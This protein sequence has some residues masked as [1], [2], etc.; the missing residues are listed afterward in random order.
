MITYYGTT[1][2]ILTKKASLVCKA[3]YLS[4]TRNTSV[5]TRIT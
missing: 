4:A 1:D 5:E 3:E 2:L